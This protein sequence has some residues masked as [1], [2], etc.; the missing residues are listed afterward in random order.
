[1]ADAYVVFHYIGSKIDTVSG[2]E[3]RV[4][5]RNVDNSPPVFVNAVADVC[6]QP[7]YL[8]TYP[9]RDTLEWH[10]RLVDPDGDPANF[11]LY[12]DEAGEPQLLNT[13]LNFLLPYPLSFSVEIITCDK[14]KIIV[15]S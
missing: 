12:F 5:F 2:N 1:M 15:I 11:K 7:V 3:D 13:T 8:G 9:L 6:T 4:I 10:L 14:Q